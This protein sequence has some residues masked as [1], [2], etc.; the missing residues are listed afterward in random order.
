MANLILTPQVFH[1]N[2]FTVMHE[3]FLL[4]EGVLQNAEGTVSVKVDA[5]KPLI[6]PA[7]NVRSHDFH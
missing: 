5:L 2:R 4:A 1:A 3:P 6:A 7:L